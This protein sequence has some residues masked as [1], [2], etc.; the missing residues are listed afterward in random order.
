MSKMFTMMSVVMMLAMLS[1]V[2]CSSPQNGVQVG[3]TGKLS[4]FVDALPPQVI[5]AAGEVAT[6]M[7]LTVASSTSSQLGGRFVAKKYDGESI[8]IN[9][10]RYG[11]NISAVS[12]KVGTWGDKNL[13]LTYFNAIKEKLA[14]RTRSASPPSTDNLNLLK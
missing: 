5:A 13:S 14:G 7:E 9:V 12:I 10:E 11:D 1:L 6:D 2:G 3:M 4:A 8:K